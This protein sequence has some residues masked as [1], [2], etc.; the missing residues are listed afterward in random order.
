MDVG[1]EVRHGHQAQVES[2]TQA[3]QGFW[4]FLLTSLSLGTWLLKIPSL[5]FTTSS[6]GEGPTVHQY[7]FFLRGK[8]ICDWFKPGSINCGLDRGLGRKMAHSEVV[9]SLSEEGKFL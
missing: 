1:S 7:L 6:I 5:H 3:S 9:L 8:K 2:R 4:P